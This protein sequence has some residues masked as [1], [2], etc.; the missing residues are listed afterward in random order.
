[1][2]NIH[3]IKDSIPSNPAMAEAFK[4]AVSKSSPD[5]GGDTLQA[6]SNNMTQRSESSTQHFAK[7]MADMTP[8]KGN[9]TM[10]ETNGEDAQMF[11]EVNEVAEP[12]FTGN[13]CLLKRQLIGSVAAL[14]ATGVT[15]RLM[16]GDKQR[17]NVALAVSAGGS[18]LHIGYCSA[19]KAL[20]KENPH[21][22]EMF[23]K[24]LTVKET[25]GLIGLNVGLT[26][27]VC[28]A[29]ISLVKKPTVV[30]TDTAE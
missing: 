9:K 16:T 29:W 10:H 21:V 6:E 8:S 3:S 28:A 22:E 13:H 30:V 20:G 5:I 23:N 7:V 26:A 27:A 17:T 11:T 2:S 1:M 14:V 25:L 19:K 18:L 4:E 15:Y 12:T 24:K